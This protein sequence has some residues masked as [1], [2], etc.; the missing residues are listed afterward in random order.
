MMC[1]YIMMCM[2][3]MMGIV[4]MVCIGIMIVMPAYWQC[5]S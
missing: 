3:I 2:F 4:G 5:A 1:M